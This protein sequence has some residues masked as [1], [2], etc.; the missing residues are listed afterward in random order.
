MALQ[1]YAGARELE[2]SPEDLDAV[3]AG[4]AAVRNTMLSY[5]FDRTAI[6]A[7]DFKVTQ[8]TLTISD[9]ERRS[10][11]FHTQADGMPFYAV[12]LTAPG[13]MMD[14]AG[15]APVPP[16]EMPADKQ[17]LLLAFE[18]GS[19]LFSRVEQALEVK[20][21]LKPDQRAGGVSMEIMS[22]NFETTTRREPRLFFDALNE[23]VN[24]RLNMLT[25]KLEVPAEEQKAAPAA[26][27][28]KPF[29]P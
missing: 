28:P 14:L 18:V 21:G 12:T 8:H 16:V 29:T 9:E 7:V 11:A 22:C 24:L 23:L 5:G 10:G 27:K 4:V 19:N 6:E 3:K 20:Y 2:M 15:G 25:P 17:A 13:S 1:H 26:K